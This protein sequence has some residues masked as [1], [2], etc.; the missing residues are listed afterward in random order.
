MD[1]RFAAPRRGV[2]SRVISG[3][4]PR[5]GHGQ[6]PS[7]HPG[8]H[9]RGAARAWGGDGHQSSVGEPWGPAGWLTELFWVAD[10]QL[11]PPGAQE[12]AQ[13]PLLSSRRLPLTTN[14]PQVGHLA[15]PCSCQLGANQTCSFERATL[16]M[17]IRA[18]DTPVSPPGT[19]QVGLQQVRSD[20]GRR[21]GVSIRSHRPVFMCLPHNR[22][23]LQTERCISF[24][25]SKMSG[26]G[27]TQE[28]VQFGTRGKTNSRSLA[29]KRN[30]AGNRNSR[31]RLGRTYVQTLVTRP[32]EA[33]SQ[34]NTWV[35]AALHSGSSG[36]RCWED[37]GIGKACPW[38]VPQP[39]PGDRPLWDSSEP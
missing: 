4:G 39:G 1:H 5:G 29:R 11:T 20:L 35:S 31:P 34:R 6:R 24:L 3:A 23:A 18:L 19:G 8:G 27:C 21:D 10:A 13:P 7:Q 32:P 12:A 2:L 37:M 17:D 33:G 30:K 28:P 36:L 22:D 15:C 9:R 14:T 38:T 16:M 25:G 26:G